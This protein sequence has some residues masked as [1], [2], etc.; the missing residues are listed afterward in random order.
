LKRLRWLTAILAN[1]LLCLLSNG[2]IL[3]LHLLEEL[4]KLLISLSVPRIGRSILGCFQ[5]MVKD[6]H[7]VIV[8][9]TESRLLGFVCH[10]L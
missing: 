6:T 7:Q 10:F 4:R 8:L 3:L 5:S 1:Q 2:V 9:I